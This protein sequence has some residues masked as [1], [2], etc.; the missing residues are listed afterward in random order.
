MR[1]EAE[2]AFINFE[3]LNIFESISIILVGMEFVKMVE[4]D[5]NKNNLFYYLIY[6]RIL[7]GMEFE[8]TVEIDSNKIDLIYYLIYFR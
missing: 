1:V 7:I 6:F 5:S 3:M 4:I 8:K 2:V